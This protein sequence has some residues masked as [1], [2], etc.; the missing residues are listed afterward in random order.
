MGQTLG[1]IKWP[2]F[3][4][5]DHGRLHKRSVGTTEASLTEERALV[6]LGVSGA[7]PGALLKSSL[8][9]R[10]RALAGYK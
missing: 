7:L 9:I 8:C 6:S 10:N 4:E 1:W 5:G 2:R 3:P